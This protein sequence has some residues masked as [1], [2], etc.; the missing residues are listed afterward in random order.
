MKVN[1]QQ[2][3]IFVSSNHL[4]PNIF[5]P[6]CFICNKKILCRRERK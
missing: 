2:K 1:D 5:L 6:F 3:L 4:T